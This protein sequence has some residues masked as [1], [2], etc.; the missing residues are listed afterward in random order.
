MKSKNANKEKE[1]KSYACPSIQTYVF[2]CV[3]IKGRKMCKKESITRKTWQ[4]LVEHNK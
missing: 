2:M 3:H 1:E 4:F